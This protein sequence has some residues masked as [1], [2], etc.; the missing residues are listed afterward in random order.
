MT[1]RNDVSRWKSPGNT[2]KQEDLR[3]AHREASRQ[4]KSLFLLN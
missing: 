4:T 1:S 3:P 2:R